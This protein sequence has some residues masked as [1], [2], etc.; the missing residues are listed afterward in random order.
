MYDVREEKDS[1]QINREKRFCSR[2]PDSGKVPMYVF[3]I[4]YL[5]LEPSNT[6]MWI[7]K[8]KT[9]LCASTIHILN[10]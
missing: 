10:P 9:M 2:I 8:W 3:L 7:G 6:H 5:F 1:I 4:S